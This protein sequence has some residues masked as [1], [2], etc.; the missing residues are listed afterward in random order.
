[1]ATHYLPSSTG[2]QFSPWISFISPPPP[3]SP[4]PPYSKPLRSPG[5]TSVWTWEGTGALVSE[6]RESLPPFPRRSHSSAMCFFS[7]PVSA[8]SPSVGPA[9]WASEAAW[10][11]GLRE[12]QL[13]SRW[14]TAA[15]QLSSQPWGRRRRRRRRREEEGRLEEG[16]NRRIEERDWRER[17]RGRGNKG[18]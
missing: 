14:E 7:L 18:R 10:S 12:R 15:S 3:L 9:P 5:R 11:L 4:P 13:L 8:G 16:E 17:G 6:A 2:R 1:M